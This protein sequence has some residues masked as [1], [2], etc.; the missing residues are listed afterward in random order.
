MKLAQTQ[1]M[2]RSDFNGLMKGFL[3][4]SVSE[5]LPELT[6]IA[7]VDYGILT[8]VLFENHKYVLVIKGDYKAPKGRQDTAFPKVPGNA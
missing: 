3:W 7:H 6:Q 1:L 2:S 8:I 4:G 5:E